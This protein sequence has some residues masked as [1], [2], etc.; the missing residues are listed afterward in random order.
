MDKRVT[1]PLCHCDLEPICPVPLSPLK[2]AQ[3]EEENLDSGVK[4]TSIDRHVQGG[5]T[6]ANVSPSLS[7]ASAAPSGASF[8]SLLGGLSFSPSF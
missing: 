1:L 5:Q 7:L 2:V 4:Q 8:F 6:W 3:G